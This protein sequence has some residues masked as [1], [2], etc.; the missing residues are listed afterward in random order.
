[1]LFLAYEGIPTPQ[2]G[3]VLDLAGEPE[4]RVLIKNIEIHFVGHKCRPKIKFK[5]CEGAPRKLTG[6]LFLKIAIWVPKAHHLQFYTQLNFSY[7]FRNL[8]NAA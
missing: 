4:G 5:I 3:V 6:A 2:P 1:M 8:L 7:S